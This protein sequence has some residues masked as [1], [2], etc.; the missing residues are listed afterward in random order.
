MS[1]SRPALRFVNIATVASWILGRT[2]RPYA[3]ERD[4]PVRPCGTC[5]KTWRNAVALATLGV[6]VLVRSV[7]ALGR[8]RRAAGRDLQDLNETFTEETN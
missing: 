5:S 2:P 4:E 8:V 7:D 3:R 1:P 6:A